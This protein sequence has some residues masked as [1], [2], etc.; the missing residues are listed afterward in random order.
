MGAAAVLIKGGHFDNAVMIT[1]WLCL[2]DT[3]PLPLRQAHVETA[4]NHG[5]G[6]TLSAAIATGLGMG[7]PLRVAVTR[8]QEF[9]NRAL[10]QSYT[11]GKG[12]G[13]LNHAAV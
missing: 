11:P 10:R 1:D 12:C 6:C 3:A 7:L 8:G 13:P 9:V 2:P 5:T 4:N